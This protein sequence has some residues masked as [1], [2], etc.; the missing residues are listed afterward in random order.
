MDSKKTRKDKSE[1]RRMSRAQEL[2]YQS[3]FKAADRAFEKF[4]SD[5]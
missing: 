2:S 3:S 5:S 1:R 4:K